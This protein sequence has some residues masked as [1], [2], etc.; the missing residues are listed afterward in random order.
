MKSEKLLSMVKFTAGEKVCLDPFSDKRLWQFY[1]LY[2]ESRQKWEKFVVL[3]FNGFDGARQFIAQQDNNDKFVGYFILDK[4]SFRTIGFIMG[5]AISD[6]E[7]SIT[8][9][10]SAKYEGR[11]YAFE[12]RQLFENLMIDA[13]FTSIVSF[14]DAENTR[15][16]ALLLRGGYEKEEARTLSVGPVSMVLETYRKRLYV[17]KY[18]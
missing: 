13:G 1:S 17:K 11:G 6:T 16:K 4:K 8:Y 15:S 2:R 18:Y 5:D 10:I 9:A 12:A 3:H 7:I 14:C